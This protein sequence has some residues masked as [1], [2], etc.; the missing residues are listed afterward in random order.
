MRDFL[1][2]DR[3]NKLS[4][5]LPH[6]HFEVLRKSG[7]PL[8]RAQ[9]TNGREKVICVR[10]LNIDNVEKKLTLLKDAS[11]EVLRRRSKNQNVESLNNSV[12]GVWSPFHSVSNYKV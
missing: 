1:V 2:S 7:H 10:N 3:L 4:Q 6:I 12:R 9:Y 11:G 5:E 8:L